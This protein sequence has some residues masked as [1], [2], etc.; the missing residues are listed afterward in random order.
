[1]TT[2]QM[3][4]AA[5]A[6][7]DG[8]PMP[9]GDDPVPLIVQRRLEAQDGCLAAGSFFEATKN[10]YAQITRAVYPVSKPLR[11]PPEVFVSWCTLRGGPGIEQGEPL[12]VEQVFGFGL[13]GLGSSGAACVPMHV[14]CRRVSE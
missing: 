9:S 1:M 2:G 3:L 5:C 13:L 4:A 11:T 8:A 14:S 10:P 12:G 7:M 6:I